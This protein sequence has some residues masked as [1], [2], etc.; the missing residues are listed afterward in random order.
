[1]DE[2]VQDFKDMEKLTIQVKTVI[3]KTFEK[4]LRKVTKRLWQV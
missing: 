2:L 1:M 4:I 3:L